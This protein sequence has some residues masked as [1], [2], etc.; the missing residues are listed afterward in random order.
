MTPILPP[1]YEPAQPSFTP[2]YTSIAGTSERVLQSAECPL[3]AGDRE[4]VYKTDHMS[5]NL[6]SLWGL[7]TPSC[8]LNGKVEGSVTFTGEQHHVERV[9]ATV[10]GRGFV[11]PSC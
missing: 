3:L 1:Y 2:A 4:W 7:H 11:A 8:G 5:I 9:T 10:R 6:G